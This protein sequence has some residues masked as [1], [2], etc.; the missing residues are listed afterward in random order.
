MEKYS[1]WTSENKK[2][3]LENSLKKIEKREDARKLLKR[4]ERKEIASLFQIIRWMKKHLSLPYL[5]ECGERENKYFEDIISIV[6]NVKAER[7][8]IERAILQLEAREWALNRMYKN[9]AFKN[10][11]LP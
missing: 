11:E 1:D 10:I 9:D 3:T 5:F 8:L 7:H 6:E 2:R 4:S